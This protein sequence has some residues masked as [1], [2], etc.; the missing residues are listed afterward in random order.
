MPEHASD[1]TP[2]AAA[3]AAA[4]CEWIGR[5]VERVAET[6]SRLQGLLEQKQTALTAAETPADRLSADLAAVIAAEATVAEELE[7][8]RRERDRWLASRPLAAEVHSLGEAAVAAGAEAELI[9]RIEA[10]RAQ[11]AA[12]QQKNWAHWVLAQRSAAHFE[13]LL[14]LI[15]RK[16]QTAA[17]YGEEL[18]GSGGGILDAAA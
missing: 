4:A 11:A 18:P 6:Q 13:E 5:H 3:V 15:A 9:E 7:T 10:A 8:L 2:E 14:G 1:Q 17:T 16:G 12:I